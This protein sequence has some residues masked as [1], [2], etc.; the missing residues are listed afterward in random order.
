M[1]ATEQED[2][3]EYSCGE[4]DLEITDDAVTVTDGEF[5]IEMTWATAEKLMAGLGFALFTR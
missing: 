2:T 1:A 4:V 3:G 5:R